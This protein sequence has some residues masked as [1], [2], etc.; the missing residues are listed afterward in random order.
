[1]PRGQ[2]E[3][4]PHHAEIAAEGPLLLAAHEVDARIETQLH[5]IEK[6]LIGEGADV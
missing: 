2:V 5:E 6:V 1:M 4:L 3:D